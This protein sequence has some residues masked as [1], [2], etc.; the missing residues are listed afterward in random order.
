MAALC[1]SSFLGP[2]VTACTSDALVD[3]HNPEPS[4]GIGFSLTSFQKSW[5]LS[6]GTHEP[7]KVIFP[8]Q[9]HGDHI[10]RA[11]ASFIAQRGVLE[12]DAVVTTQR[13]L[14]IAVRTAD[15]LPCLLFA[16][17]K[18]V[19]AAVHA[20]W[21][22]T[23]LEIFRKTIELLKTSYGIDPRLLKAALGPCIRRESYEVGPEFLEYFPRDVKKDGGRL[24]FDLL[25]ANT[26]Q[27]ATC[28]VAREHIFDIDRDTVSDTGLHSFRRDGEKAGR[29]L[30]FIMML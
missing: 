21:K 5:L 24:C 14:P 7:D 4:G 29:M 27:L 8:K 9:V 11:D 26:R 6:C 25:A 12:A 23:K 19:I 16:P 28:G 13:G 15:C 22:S 1:Y 17:D 2:G 20:G 30:S 18:G 3:F 10:W